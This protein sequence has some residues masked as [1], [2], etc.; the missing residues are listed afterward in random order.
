[1]ARTLTGAEIVVR[2]LEDEAIPF[3]FGIPGTHNIELYDA[4]SRSDAVRA[5]LVT[6]EQGASFMADGVS[7]ASGALGCLNLVPGAGVTHAMSGIAEAFLDGI[8]LL[9]LAC[10]V[11][12]DSD[13]AYQLHDVDQTAMVAPVTKARLHPADGRD[14]YATVRRACRIAR[15]PPAGPV[16]VEVP[17]NLYLFRHDP[18]FE[19][20]QPEPDR[21]VEPPAR[22]LAKVRS[23]LENARRPLIYLGLGAAGAAERLVELAERL[24]APVATTFQGK[25]VFPERH[26]LWLWPGFGTAAPP[27][28]RETASSCDLTLAI[29]CRFSEVG[30]GSYGLEPPGP[31]VHVDIDPEVLDRN[32]PTDVEIV[33]DA[34]AF[35]AALLDG[36]PD[37][38][39]DP[40]LRRS[41]A[42]G[43]D[44]VQARWSNPPETGRVAPPLLL[45][46]VQALY[47]PEAV[48]TADSG[49]GT[50]LAME[51]LRLDQP[52]SFLAPVDYS[53]MGYSV[54]AAVGAALACP[55]RRA[56]ALAG[57]GAFLMTGLELLTAAQLDVPLT[58]IVLRDQELAQIAQFQQTALARKTASRLPDYDLEALSRATGADYLPLP[59]NRE[60]EEV[61]RQAL[62]GHDAG[63]RVVVEAAV[64]YSTPTYFTRGVVRTNLGRLPWPE[65]LRFVARALAR[66]VP[67]LGG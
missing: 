47:G 46:T 48:F 10:G 38:D 28:V 34:A 7:R 64:D 3:T 6:D 35:V 60:V 41:I 53:C 56:V 62:A 59:R 16:F 11:R 9:V 1:M 33:A 54:P 5:V 26:P 21:P 58:V 52:R 23:L 40:A 12:T 42:E 20:W 37:R 55:G 14:L 24:E 45:Q 31:L 51:C 67:G 25:G 49:N 15:R 39:P 65:R 19:G 17:V 29:G 32:Y 22:E 36:L 43:H 4:L 8:P 66:R 30:T 44:D 63:R 61:L 50:F 27:F 18:N 13:K 57:D 2:A